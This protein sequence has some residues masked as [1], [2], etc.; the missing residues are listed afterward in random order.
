[1]PGTP[2]WETLE[3]LLG[4]G[5]GAQKLGLTGGPQIALRGGWPGPRGVPFPS[6]A[7]YTLSPLWAPCCWPF[8][9]P[10]LSSR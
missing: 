3:K 6:P 5:L 9:A 4:L 10:A 1:M 8:W 2:L 7:C